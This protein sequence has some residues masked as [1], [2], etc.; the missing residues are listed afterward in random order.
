MKASPSGPYCGR[1]WRGCLG[2]FLRGG[3]VDCSEAVDRDEYVSA[4]GMMITGAGVAA[5]V[6]AGW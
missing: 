1:G 4:S 3:T 5:A 2:F 6:M